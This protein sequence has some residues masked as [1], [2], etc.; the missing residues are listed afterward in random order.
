MEIRQL[1]EE[2]LA[3]KLLLK[4]MKAE[5]KEQNKK[6]FPE[7]KF[8]R[9]YLK[10][11]RAI[12]S[13]LA[14]IYTDTTDMLNGPIAYK[15]N[16]LKMDAQNLIKIAKTVTDTDIKVANRL[17]VALLEL[18][19][20]YDKYDIERDHVELTEELRVW[21]EKVR[22]PKDEEKMKQIKKLVDPEI[23]QGV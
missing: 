14:S 17:V 21:I 13:P 23:L 18:E 22:P 2:I 6:L 16:E 8:G 19:T 10:T 5:E 1:E 11:V 12:T 15:S 7:T 9:F 4:V 20:H 3:K